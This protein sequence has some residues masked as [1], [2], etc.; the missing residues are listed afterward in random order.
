MHYVI[1]NDNVIATVHATADNINDTDEES[2][3]KT[4]T[5]EANARLIA[6]APDMLATL[7][8]L[9]E[10][11]IDGDLEDTITII[12]AS[13]SKATGNEPPDTSNICQDCGRDMYTGA[14]CK[15]I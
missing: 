3:R 15:N 4:E 10:K 11:I 5:D 14:P 9:R 1:A 8:R 6:A 2:E 7:S 12:D 13:I